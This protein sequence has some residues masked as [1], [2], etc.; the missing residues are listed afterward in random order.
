[1]GCEKSKWP[2][3]KDY[4][5]SPNYFEIHPQKTNFDVIG[6]KALLLSNIAILDAMIS[7]KRGMNPVAM[8]INLPQN[9]SYQTPRCIL[10]D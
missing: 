4:K 10:V 9:T 2:P 3:L 8:T 5:A 7:S 6:R 1:M